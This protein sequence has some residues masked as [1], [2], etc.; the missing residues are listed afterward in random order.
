MGILDFFWKSLPASLLGA[1][2]FSESLGTF[3][4]AN[5]AGTEI[6]TPEV[7]VEQPLHKLDLVLPGVALQERQG[8][9]SR[10]FNPMFIPAEYATINCCIECPSSSAA[11]R[12]PI[13]QTAIP[14][15]RPATMHSRLAAL[16][17]SKMASRALLASA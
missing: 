4:L 2:R 16:R 1:L 7:A 5:P 12:P 17:P 9:F 15:R 13:A 14:R 11:T 3:Q 10:P 8:L 6:I